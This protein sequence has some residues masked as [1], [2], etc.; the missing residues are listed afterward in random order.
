MQN[1]VE[2]LG[3]QGET[4]LVTALNLPTEILK[5][6]RRNFTT[7]LMQIF[8]TPVYCDPDQEEINVEWFGNTILQRYGSLKSGFLYKGQNVPQ[9]WL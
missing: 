6:S 5:E 8:P 7:P 4:G 2:F 3:L 9:K 1:K